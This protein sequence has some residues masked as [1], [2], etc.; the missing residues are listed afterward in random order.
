R[1]GYCQTGTGV[2]IASICKHTGKEMG[3]CEKNHRSYSVFL[4]CCNTWCIY[5]Q[6]DQIS[7]NEGAVV[8]QRFTIDEVI[9]R[10]ERILARGI[11][12]VGFV[13][14]SPSFCR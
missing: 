5:C 13:S 7:R 11:R 9:S 1:L 3:L 8:G 10:I 2:R 4:T 6:N 12:T 14:P